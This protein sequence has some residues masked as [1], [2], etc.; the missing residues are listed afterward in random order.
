[1][2]GP[3]RKPV[4]SRRSTLIGL[5]AKEVSMKPNIADIIRHHVSLEVRCIDRVYQHAYMPKLQTSGGLCYFL[6]DHLGY[7]IPSPALSNPSGVALSRRLTDLSNAT[8]SRWSNSSPGKTKMP[9]PMLTAPALRRAK[10]SCLVGTAQEKLLAFK[11]HKRCGPQ[12]GVTFDFS[13]QWVAVKHYYFYVHDRDWGPAFLKIGTY[14]PYPVNLCLNG[15]EWVKQRLRRDRVRFESLDNG[16]LACP[17][18]DGLQAACDALGPADIQAF[19]D[20]WSHRLP[21]PMMPP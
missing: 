16:F 12:G 17:D 6:T 14:L 7:P 15:H 5:P 20:R 3:I 18:P 19:F 11:A 4:R 13:R 8:R 9:L 10:G 1:M 21:W 2:L